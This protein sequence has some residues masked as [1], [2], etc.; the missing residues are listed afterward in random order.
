MFMRDVLPNTL[1]YNPVFSQENNH[2]LLGS[3]L[4]NFG[5]RVCYQLSNPAC[6][7]NPLVYYDGGREREREN[8]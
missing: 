6:S 4:P 3:E 1:H 7:K 8:S 2:P 5:V